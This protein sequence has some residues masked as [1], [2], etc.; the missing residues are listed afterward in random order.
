MVQRSSDHTL[1]EAPLVSVAITTYNSASVLARAI[2]SV[3]AQKTDFPV[4]IVIGD[5]CSQDGT[6]EVAMDYAAQYS[7]MIRVL[8]Q[9]ANVGIQRNYY[10]TFEACRG[11]YIAWLDADDYWTDPEK[12]T[13]QTQLL[14]ADPT[15]SACGHLVRFVT[16]DEQVVKERH[17]S[18]PTGRFGLEEATRLVF[19]P[20]L[21]VVFRNGIQRGLPQWYFDLA[22][23]T[24]WPIWILAAKAGDLV[25]LD[26]V[27]GDYTLTPGSAFMGQGLLYG[28][29]MDAR[30][31]E[32]VVELLSG[33]YVRI[34]KA[35]KGLRYEAIAYL[36]RKEGDFVGSRKA[37]VKAFVAPALLDNVPTKAKALLAAVIREWQWRLKPSRR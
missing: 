26:R 17:P 9:P 35:E 16:P 25:L 23:T 33:K 21:S 18:Y 28:K 11:K 8:A 34:A 32:Y 24:D 10:E 31:Y 19:F 4:E 13:I 15:I 2:G 22:P 14:E 36:L 30:F 37:A 12:L 29:R 7:G 6:V 5:D 3:L 1:A 27:M 20:S